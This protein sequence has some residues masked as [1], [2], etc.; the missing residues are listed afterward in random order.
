MNIT[1]DN[2]EIIRLFL[3]VLIVSYFWSCKNNKVEKNASK[4]IVNEQI[5]KEL[6][7]VAIIRKAL[8]I[9]GD[10][11]QITLIGSLNIVYTQGSV[12]TIDVEGPSNMVNHVKLSVDSGTLLA[13]INTEDNPD[14]QIIE[15][16]NSNLVLYITSP[17]LNIVSP[18]GSGS[19]KAVGIVKSDNFIA[20]TLGDGG[21]EFDTLYCNSFRYEGKN[22]SSSSFKYVEVKEHVEILGESSSYVNA[23]IK[24]EGDMVLTLNSNTSCD[25]DGFSKSVEILAFGKSKCNVGVNTGGLDISAY[26]DA[27]VN[28]SGTYKYK[29]IKK[30]TTSKVEFSSK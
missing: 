18:C 17:T 1:V 29:D 20:G 2:K 15:K 3:L 14:I 19:F 24:T 5:N 10:F 13:A 28:Y 21:I 22:A 30:G 25:I 6:D 7:S 27:Y 4:A 9:P 23:N 12:C 8:P 11:S 16:D 26:Q